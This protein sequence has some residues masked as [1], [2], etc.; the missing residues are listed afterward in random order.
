M[1]RRWLSWVLFGFAGFDHRKAA[2]LA[3]SPGI[4]PVVWLGGQVVILAFH[5]DVNAS[6]EACT[7]R[8]AKRLYRY[9]HR[10]E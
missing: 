10:S 4:Y 5:R 3:G 9:L 7:T 8:Q 1:G 2:D 6:A